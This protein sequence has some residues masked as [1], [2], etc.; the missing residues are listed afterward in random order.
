M[1]AAML[2]IIAWIR[3]DGR[4]A[5]VVVAGSDQM[6]SGDPGLDCNTTLK[7]GDLVFMPSITKDM[8]DFQTGLKL[9]RSGYWPQIVRDIGEMAKVPAEDTSGPSA[10]SNVID[11]FTSRTRTRKP[12]PKHRDLIGPMRLAAE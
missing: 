10:G 9:V 5:L 6:A 11:L 12:V 4:K 2:G 7:V 1:G 3:P 8:V